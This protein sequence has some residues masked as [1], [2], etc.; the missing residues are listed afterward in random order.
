[1]RAEC[2]GSS[3]CGGLRCNAGV[4][5]EGLSGGDVLNFQK[6][7]FTFSILFCELVGCSVGLTGRFA[8]WHFVFCGC[9]DLM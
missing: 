5:V 1:M 8:A 4:G 2:T 6:E 3:F 9:V 7:R